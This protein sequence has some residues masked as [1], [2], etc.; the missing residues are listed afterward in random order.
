M[1]LDSNSW[2]VEYS[3]GVLH[4]PMQANGFKVTCINNEHNV[5]KVGDN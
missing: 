2:R 1:A 3:G 5:R 4:G